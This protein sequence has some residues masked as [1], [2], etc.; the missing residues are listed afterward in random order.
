MYIVSLNFA[1]MFVGIFTHTFR[2]VLSPTLVSAEEEEGSLN[3]WLCQSYSVQICRHKDRLYGTN[4]RALT[5]FTAFRAEKYN[6][7]YIF[8]RTFFNLLQA[9]AY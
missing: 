7:I 8:P 2:K 6:E 5:F 9:I 1:M 3:R 4:L